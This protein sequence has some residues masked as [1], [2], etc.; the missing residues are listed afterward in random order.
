MVNY[1]FQN[2]FWRLLLLVF[3]VDY[4]VYTFCRLNSICCSIIFKINLHSLASLLLVTLNKLLLYDYTKKF[5][6]IKLNKNGYCFHLLYCYSLDQRQLMYIFILDFACLTSSK[7]TQSF[8][9]SFLCDPNNNIWFLTDLG[10]KWVH[11][12]LHTKLKKE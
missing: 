10:D 12:L 9:F 3:I 5:M 7:Q 1:T 8:S 2:M 6:F 11:I 4:I